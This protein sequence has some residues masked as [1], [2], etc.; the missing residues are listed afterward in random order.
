MTQCDPEAEMICADK[1]SL[2]EIK[3]IHEFVLSQD[4]LWSVQVEDHFGELSWRLCQSLFG[5]KS[6]KISWHS[7]IEI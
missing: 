5:F 2:A 1:A 3:M 7:K 6:L 4:V